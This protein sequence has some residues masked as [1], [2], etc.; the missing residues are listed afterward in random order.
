MLVLKRMRTVY[1]S[2]SRTCMQ[3]SSRSIRGTRTRTRV[4]TRYVLAARAGAAC[5]VLPHAG[6]TAEFPFTRDHVQ[7]PDPGPS[8]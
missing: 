1:K 2:R 4:R 5:A 8:H 7:V 6:R 3:L